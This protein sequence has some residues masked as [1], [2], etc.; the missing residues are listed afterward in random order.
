MERYLELQGKSIE[1]GATGL[2]AIEKPRK[3][4]F[5]HV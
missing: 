5:A 1:K 4:Y 3:A 2:D